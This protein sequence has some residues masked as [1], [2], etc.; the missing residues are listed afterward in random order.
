MID[1]D[2]GCH[3]LVEDASVETSQAGVSVKCTFCVLAS[4]D[5][6]QVGKKQTEYFSVDG[7][8]VDKLYNLAQ[9]CGLITAEQR[10]AAAEQ[11]MGLDIDEAQL[12][13]KQFCAE[14]KM[15]LNM[16]KNPATGTAEVDPVKPGPYPKIGFRSFSITDSK[17]KAIPK[18][19]Q[20]LGL[21]AGGG[22]L[23]QPTQSQ[24]TQ[25]PTQQQNL[26]GVN[27]TPPATAM[28]W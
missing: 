26:P 6:S 14:I 12:K 4:T 17:A 19:Q 16:R 13:G 27:P 25:Q 9:A 15:E 22:Q 21:I 20:F 1:G 11:G 23:Q 3:L 8:S 28:N 7:K 24:Q 5:S 10:K 2:C 18:D